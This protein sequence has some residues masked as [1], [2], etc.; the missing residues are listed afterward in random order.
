MVASEAQPMP[1]KSAGWHQS[2]NSTLLSRKRAITVSSEAR[3]H[4]TEQEPKRRSD[5]GRTDESGTNSRPL[6][7][8]LQPVRN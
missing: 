6:I 1:G 4:R 2:N 5:S 3:V 7:G 8:V